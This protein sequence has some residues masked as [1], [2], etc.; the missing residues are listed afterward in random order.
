LVDILQDR[1][2]ETQIRHELLQARIL[3]LQLF[4]L[5]HL[6]RLQAGVLLLSAIKRLL[7]NPHLPGQIRHRHPQLSLLKHRNN[8]F[9]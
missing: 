5:S 4:E 3:V 9:D 6:I 8:L 1:L 7:R 2:I